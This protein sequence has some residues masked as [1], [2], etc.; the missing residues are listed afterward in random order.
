M[1]RFNLGRRSLEPELMDCP[2]LNWNEHR[3]ALEGLE[4]I[5][6][7]SLAVEPIWRALTENSLGSSRLKILDIATGAGDL[8]L[9][10]AKKAKQNGFDF[11][12]NACDKSPQ[13][14]KYAQQK[15]DQDGVDIHFF[16]LDIKKEKIPTGYDI[17]IN[18]LFLHHLSADETVSF[19]QNLKS[20][21]PKMIILN[22]LSRTHFGFFLA[23]AGTRFLSRS[24]V[25]HY[26]GPQSVK[27]A[28]TIPEISELAEE[29]GLRH[30]KIQ[31]FW[32]ARFLLTWKN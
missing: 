27:A 14:V 4:R 10:L 19:I 25:V 20:A 22:D 28:Y 32:P 18:A 29:A 16:S 31:P 6:S 3:E 26:D 15:A 2:D 12:I 5:N 1:S 24:K 9:V 23:Y 7:F 21:S 30:F 11:K 17:L 8:P 13:A